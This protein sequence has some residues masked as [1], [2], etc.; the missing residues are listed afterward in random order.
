MIV[1]AEKA[2]INAISGWEPD[3]TLMTEAGSKR[4]QYSKQK[5]WC[6]VPLALR[7]IEWCKLLD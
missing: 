7:L 3:C 2:G 5:F 1:A 6:F 4:T